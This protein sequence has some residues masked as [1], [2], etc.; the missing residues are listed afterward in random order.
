VAEP[1]I[2]TAELAKLIG[3][4]ARTIQLWVA[5]GKLRPTLTTPGGRYRWRLSDVEDQL[6][7]QPE[8]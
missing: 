2:T 8:E 4:S 3:V 5:S 1:M 6:R 7:R